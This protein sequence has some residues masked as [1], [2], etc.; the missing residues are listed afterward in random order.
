L[1][2]CASL[3]SKLIA[4][5]THGKPVFLHGDVHPKNIFLNEESLFLLDLDQAATGPALADLGSVIS[6]L[7]CDALHRHAHLA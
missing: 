6:G 5:Y 4:Q 2:H 1:Q 3:S 7:Y